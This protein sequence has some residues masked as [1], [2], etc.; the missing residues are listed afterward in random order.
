MASEIKI[1]SYYDLPQKEKTDSS[2]PMQ[3][4]IRTEKSG[5][6][7][8]KPTNKNIPKDTTYPFIQPPRTPQNLRIKPIDP[9]PQKTNEK[10]KP[11]P[12]PSTRKS[13]N[14]EP[15]QPPETNPKPVA[16]ISINTKTNTSQPPNNGTA[17]QAAKNQPTTF[18]TLDKI[19]LEINAALSKIK[20]PNK[21]LTVAIIEK[22]IIKES[23]TKN[24][25]NEFNPFAVSQCGAFGTMQIMPIALQNAADKGYLKPLLPNNETTFNKVKN[26]PT[27]TATT[28][29]QK[30]T[31]PCIYAVS[32]GTEPS[33]YAAIILES[34]ED[35]INFDLAFKK[36][37][38]NDLKSKVIK[39]FVRSKLQTKGTLY[40]DLNTIN[41][42]IG[43]S[44]LN[45]YMERSSTQ[46]EALSRY[47]GTPLDEN[48]TS[49]YAMAVL[50]L[51]TTKNPPK[52][53]A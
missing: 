28:I 46:A 14:K 11:K 21:K 37:D 6:S 1:G 41:L 9:T 29:P 3:P 31:W 42:A 51:D 19:R 44:H 17:T 47:N 26:M 33:T 25:N 27:Y 30:D 43:I 15:I 53:P 35:L 22:L 23:G 2:K 10:E 16:P 39:N 49:S 50:A 40:H 8:E 12:P 20:H 7:Q 48:R 32:Y 34:A 24:K 38:N 18:K 5:T 52:K 13:L 36:D 45:W 4:I